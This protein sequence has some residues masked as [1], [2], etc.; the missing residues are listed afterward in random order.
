MES[1]SR[2]N[3][4][5]RSTWQVCGYCLFYLM[6][7]EPLQHSSQT[8]SRAVVNK[9]VAACKKIKFRSNWSEDVERL[10]A[11]VVDVLPTSLTVAES[12]CD[13]IYYFVRHMGCLHQSWRTGGVDTVDLVTLAMTSHM[14]SARMQELGAL[15]LHTLQAYCHDN[16]RHVVSCNAA[17]TLCDAADAHVSNVKVQIHVCAALNHSALIAEL[18]PDVLVRAKQV[19]SRAKKE[20]RSQSKYF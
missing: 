11:L 4:D 16:I 17:T 6:R 2:L 9:A 18:T 19:A 8:P 15:A 12:Y 13:A 5:V 20:H 3:T 14:S 1:V 10:N 7:C